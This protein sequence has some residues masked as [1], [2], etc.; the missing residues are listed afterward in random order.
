MINVDGQDTFKVP[1]TEYE[2]PIEALSTDRPNESFRDRVRPRRLDR[3]ANGKNAGA[4]KYVVKAARELV[5][6]IPNQPAYRFRALADGPGH[7]PCVLR[8]PLLVRM[9]CAAGEVHP[10]TADFNEE[11]DVQ[12][13][14][15]NRVDGKEI[16][17]DEASRLRL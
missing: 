4:P 1:R 5:I 14:E 12:P 13:L 10:P 3:R 11:Q 15:P 2:Q 7:W 17:S 9:G 16:D 6:A 8:D